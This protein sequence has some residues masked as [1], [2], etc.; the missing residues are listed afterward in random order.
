MT[1]FDLGGIVQGVAENF[2]YRSMHHEIQPLSI[3]LI[4]VASSYLTLKLASEGGERTL[5]E[6]EAI[7]EEI[8]P[9]EEFSYFFLNDILNRSYRAENNFARIVYL[10][11]GLAVFIS[12]LGLLGMSGYTT[13]LRSKEIA[14]RRVLGAGSKSVT[15]LLW[16]R[17][18]VLTGIALVLVAP[19]CWYLLQ[20]WLANFAYRTGIGV[21]PFLMALFS[22]IAISL[23]VTGFHTLKVFRRPVNSGLERE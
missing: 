21:L 19:V 7:W 3:I 4:P 14:V 5:E 9:G 17:F 2:N 16:R 22:I 15:V 18:L 23:L 6:I 13:E 1:Q 12:F 10:F 11:T 20:N 8:L